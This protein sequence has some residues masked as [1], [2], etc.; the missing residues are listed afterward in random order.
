M[1]LY[2]LVSKVNVPSVWP[3]PHKNPPF[4]VNDS[5]APY[6]TGLAMGMF[7]TWSNVSVTSSVQPDK[8]TNHDNVIGRVS[9]AAL[10]L[11]LHI[12]YGYC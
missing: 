10:V 7:V 3:F 9:I 12:S 4:E 2:R 11:S 6:T 5:Y 8:K 1:C